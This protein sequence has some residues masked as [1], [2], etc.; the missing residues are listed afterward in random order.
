MTW[1]SSPLWIA[2][3]WLFQ[4]HWIRIIWFTIRNFSFWFLFLFYFFLS[5]IFC[6]CSIIFIFR[7]RWIVI[8]IKLF[9]FTRR[10]LVLAKSRVN[11]RCQHFVS[12]QIYLESLS[13]SGRL[14]LRSIFMLKWYLELKLNKK[15]IRAGFTQWR[16]C[17]FFKGT[18]PWRARRRKYLNEA[19][20]IQNW[21]FVTDQVDIADYFLN[22]MIESHQ[23]KL[24]SYQL[25]MLESLV[26]LESF[27]F[28]FL[29]Y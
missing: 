6:P 11:I 14:L 23:K 7:I 29:N 15:C 9:P 26:L 8:R 25:R 3:Q 20:Y 4:T 19:V 16:T 5:S 18:V 1:T 21:L 17:S 22:H 24:L 2:I 13:R 12:P 10:F 28:S 27:L